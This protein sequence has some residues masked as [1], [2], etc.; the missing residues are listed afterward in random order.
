[1]IRKS[2]KSGILSVSAILAFLVVF[3]FA[4]PVSAEEMIRRD[5]DSEAWFG[6]DARP[7]FA[8]EDEALGPL[9]W[10]AAIRAAGGYLEP[11]PGVGPGFV[12]YGRG[13]RRRL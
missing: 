12:A 8:F 6:L 1:M 3:S 10:P 13:L 2:S 7:G 5:A 4:A 9:L 11:R